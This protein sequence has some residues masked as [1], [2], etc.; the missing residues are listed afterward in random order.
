M[1]LNAL[2]IP[3]TPIVPPTSRSVSFS[4]LGSINSG[5]PA[6]DALLFDPAVSLQV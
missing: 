2:P 3:A 1:A 6:G 4:P 5:A